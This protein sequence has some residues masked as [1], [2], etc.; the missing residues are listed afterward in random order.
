MIL[1]D[2][3]IRAAKP[4]EKEYT[5]SDGGGLLLA[6]RGS[7]KRWVLRYHWNGKEKRAGLGSYPEVGLADAREK[8]FQFR[9]ELGRGCNPQ[10]R[11][12]AEREAVAKEEAIKSMT[13][14]RVAEDWFT[15]QFGAWSDSHCTDVRHKLNAYI[16]P[17]IG[18]RPVSEINTQE[19]LSLLLDIEK[20]TPET[21]KK[22]KWNIG[23]ILRFAIG[24]GLAENDVTANLRGM[25]K[26]KTIRHF[27][28]LTKP[29]DVADLIV[30]IDAYNGSPIVRS[31]LWFSLYTFQRPG[32]IRRA[33][34]VEMD[35]DATLWR[36]SAPTMKNRKDHV[37]P[38]SRQVLEILEKLRYM[39]GDS[40]FVFPTITSNSKP[41]SENTVR[42]AL[43]S[44]GYTNEQMTAHGFRTLAS[45]NLNEQGWNSDLIE[46]QLAHVEGNS[47]RAAYNRAERLEERR[48]MMQEWANWLDSLKK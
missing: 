10:E 31:A 27:G 30:R 12:R 46:L 35:I 16:L 7:S 5:L 42:V 25:L 32:E 28:A 14:E 34:W 43:R 20:R 9:R 3:A 22:C 24:R 13:F 39:T 11:K 6:V 1:T 21:A 29:D 48:N 37:V 19:V 8:A 26:P 4:K 44:L 40:R 47:V 45:T 41:M 36:L 23:Q 18:A 38:L 33:E 2:T 17:A 15:Q